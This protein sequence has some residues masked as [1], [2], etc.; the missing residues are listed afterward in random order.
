MNES[1]PI[2]QLSPLYETYPGVEIS[3]TIIEHGKPF[4]IELRHPHLEVGNLLEKRGNNHIRLSILKRD[5]NNNPYF[6][7]VFLESER[8][9][10]QN[11]FKVG[12][13]YTRVYYDSKP[14]IKQYRIST[15]G[16]AIY[17]PI[18]NHSV[19]SREPNDENSTIEREE[20]DA[21]FRSMLKGQ[22]IE[23]TDVTRYPKMIL[24]P[25][26]DN[27]WDDPNIWR[28]VGDNTTKEEMPEKGSAVIDK[29]TGLY[30]T[31]EPGIYMEES[32]RFFI[33]YSSILKSLLL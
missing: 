3:F 13:L 1:I 5:L 24:N 23:V 4:I 10:R 14:V 22:P 15:G 12:T 2:Q 30:I 29:Y 19:L 21:L 8:P 9:V 6:Y 18:L 25:V 27:K 11:E 31:Y 17:D 16:Q 32:F 33:S 26:V 28:I 7:L 20:A